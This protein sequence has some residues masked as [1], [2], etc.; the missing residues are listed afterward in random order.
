MCD[1]ECKNFCFPLFLILDPKLEEALHH[2]LCFGVEVVARLA[3]L[4]LFLDK[5]FD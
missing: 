1:S 5:D 3:H 4:V 2:Q